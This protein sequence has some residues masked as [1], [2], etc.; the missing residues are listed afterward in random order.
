MHKITKIYFGII[1]ENYI[2]IKILTNKK[3]VQ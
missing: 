2:F 1:I 3:K